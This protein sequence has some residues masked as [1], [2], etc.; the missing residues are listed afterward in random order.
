M[1]CLEPRGLRTVLH[2]KTPIYGFLALDRACL[3][4]RSKFA[5]NSF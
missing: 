1:S 3:H 2:V 4:I 5:V